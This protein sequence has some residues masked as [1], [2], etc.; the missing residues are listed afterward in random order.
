MKKYHL[1]R[2]IGI[3]ALA[4]TLL[5]TPAFARGKININTASKRRLEQLPGIGEDIAALIVSYR[6][7]NGPFMSVSQLR[8]IPGI[9]EK[10]LQA[11]EDIAITGMPAPRINSL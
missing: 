9:G 6:R 11:I 5:S 7:E 10:R 4:V 1:G 8:N 3:A 2:L